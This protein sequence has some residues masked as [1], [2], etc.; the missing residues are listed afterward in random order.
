MAPKAKAP[1]GTPRKIDDLSK[2]QK[3]ALDKLFTVHG[4]KAKTGLGYQ[5]ILGAYNSGALRYSHRLEIGDKR[6]LPLFSE[7]ELLH[8]KAIR[9]TRSPT[10][11]A[12]DKFLAEADPAV[13]QELLEKYRTQT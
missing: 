1:K 11:E 10:V 2:P 8:W 3:D 6:S 9:G 4:A 7:T 5:T 13:V 12:V